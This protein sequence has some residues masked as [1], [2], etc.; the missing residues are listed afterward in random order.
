MDKIKLYAVIL[1]FFILLFAAGNVFATNY[2]IDAV[3]GNDNN[4]GL[5]PSKAWKSIN[6][7]S[8]KSFNPGD[9]V[10]L[11][12]GQSFDGCNIY[13]RS[14][15]NRHKLDGVTFNSFGSGPRP[16]IKSVTWT[17]GIFI[18]NQNNVHF[19]GLEFTRDSTAENGFLAFD[20]CPGLIIDSC[21][22]NGQGKNTRDMLWIGYNTDTSIVRNCLFENGGTGDAS[23]YGYVHGFYGS[24][25]YIIVENS[26]FINNPY[27]NGLKSNV[28]LIGGVDSYCSHWTIR[29]N[30]FEGNITGAFF[31]SLDSSAIYDNVFVNTLKYSN[32]IAFSQESG[33]GFMPRN[34]K[35]FNNTIVLAKNLSNVGIYL[36]GYADIDSI[37]IKN[38]IIYSQGGSG[39]HYAIYQQPGG[40]QNIFINNNLY[41]SPDGQNGFWSLRGTSYNSFS[42]WQAAGYDKKGKWG[43]PLFNNLNKRDFTLKKGSPAKKLGQ[44]ISNILSGQ[45]D[46]SL[47][48]N[49]EHPDAGAI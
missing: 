42:S 15:S 9:V 29:D 20:Y 40:G 22:F 23:R 45:T 38:N 37:T 7:V 13:L 31:Q 16:I 44:P 21:V 2:Y 28:N 6:V 49:N 24:G 34:V 19:Y 4:S 5:S 36:Y 47:S 12:A 39:E 8:N 46:K 43:N 18:D 1:S 17:A 14:V 35:V 30:Y 27:G 10:S 25:N 26:R 33:L 32:A 11:A 41:Y 48:G 3:N